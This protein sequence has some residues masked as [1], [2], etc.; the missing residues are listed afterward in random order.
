MTEALL[1]ELKKITPEERKI[2]EGQTSIE[3]KLYMTAETNVIDAAKLLRA[4]R[5]LEVRTHTRF[6]HFPEHTHNYVEVIYM[7]AGQTHHV[8]DGEEV[9]LNQGE[10]LFLNQKAKQEIY[11]AGAEDIAVNF[12]ILPEFFDNVLPLIDTEE[13]LLH[14]FVVDCLMGRT[15]D[16]GYLHFKVADILPIQNLV[17][18]LIWT[19][20]N[21]QQNKRKINQTT[22]ALLFLQ[23]MN[24][25]D[26]IEVRE[27]SPQ[28]K[29]MLE[30]LSFVEA[31]YREGEL[32]QLAKQMN[33]DMYWL[34]REIKR[35][36]GKNY[37]ELVQAKRLSQAE[38]LLKNTKK[39]VM[40]IGMA[41]GYE[42]V[43]YFHRI[44]QKKY[45]MTPRAYRLSNAN[46]T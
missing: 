26:K 13:N 1:S 39:T 35:Q 43:S 8:V 41:V 16:G 15:E 17:E 19:L 27:E 5:L 3:K 14:D 32:T 21:E 29:L 34:S 33:Y 36:T 22:M 24:H 11:P 7:C 42:N 10:L 40:E 46:R 30:V 12:I 18:N 2:L 4:G 31:H 23:L 28:Q 6:V 45:G 9:F 37:T 38:Y 20:W 25:M 44:F